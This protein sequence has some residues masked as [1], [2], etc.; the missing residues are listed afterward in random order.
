MTLKMDDRIK[1]EHVT[2]YTITD[3]RTFTEALEAAKEQARLDLYEIGDS[4][5]NH[6]TISGGSD[7]TECCEKNLEKLLATLTRLAEI[8][9]TT[10]VLPPPIP[11]PGKK[12]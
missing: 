3:G 6:D 7:F 9:A 12:R 4:W 11:R 2:Q 8:K 10:P 5:L 1:S